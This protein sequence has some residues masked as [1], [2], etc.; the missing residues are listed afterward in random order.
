[1][2]NGV[3]TD[4]NDP[5]LTHGADHKPV[6]QAEVYAVLSAEE[7]AKGF[8]RPFRDVYLHA[9]KRGGCGKTTKINSREIAET[10]ARNPAFYQGGYCVHCK[11]HRPNEEFE[12]LDGSQ[13]GT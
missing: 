13:V 8:V 2:K 4:L 6:E 12:W 7:R 3:T 5:R 1:M 11:M 9:G 10:L